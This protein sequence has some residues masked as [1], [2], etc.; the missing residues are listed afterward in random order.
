MKQ[1]LAFWNG[2]TIFF[3]IIVLLGIALR[4]SYLDSKVYWIDE[5]HTSLRASGYSRAEFV[6]LAPQ[7]EIVGIESLQKFQKLTPERN[8]LVAMK[9]ISSSEHSPFYYG[10]TRVG[11]EL[12]GSSIKV[13]RGVA[14]TLSL[15]LFPS[16]YWLTQELF[17]SR[18]ISLA[19]TALIAVSP[20]QILYAQ[21]AR[22]YSLFAVTIVLASAVFLRVIK[23]NSSIR[24][25]KQ[26]N[27]FWYSLAIAFGLYTHP[28]FVLV[29]LAH[30]FFLLITTNL[31]KSNLFKK[32]LIST[33]WGIFLFL[34]W[35]AVF[36]FNEDGVGM[37]IERDISLKFWLQRWVLNISATF[38]DFQG[39]FP[40]IL[41]DVEK[42][43]DFTFSFDNAIS[44][45]I[46]P[47][48]ALI[49]YSIYF[50]IK[51]S[52]RQ[53]SYFILLLMGV[54]ILGL[55][56]PD[57]LFGG[58]RSTIARYILAVIVSIQI[59][60]GYFFANKMNSLNA[61]QWQ[62][63]LWRGLFCLLITLSLISSWQMVQAPTWWNKYSSYYNAEVA[64]IINQ[65]ENPLIISNTERISRSTSLSYL[66]K[67]DAK[68]LL[69]DEKDTI[70]SIA[71]EYSQIFL[72]RPFDD[73]LAQ[74]QQNESYKI[75]PIF[76]QG[77]L[78]QLSIK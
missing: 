58:Q 49:F 26:F 72:F 32:Y 74:L 39:I 23:S 51:H 50:L 5:V 9:A 41:F 4:F 67:N 52:Y 16:I 48:F 29:M 7:G 17:N 19:V 34:P 43:Q 47:L 6:E 69:L 15:F 40:E 46:I 59:I 21:E 3:A 57:L 31:K 64:T 28:L 33:G 25:K 44:L 12:F 53:S 54:T 14:A 2:T 18:L 45:L 65:A 71:S 68:F 66:L 60:V 62:N 36:I 75:E 10:L 27:W 37:W 61:K 73:F 76:A 8:F 20:L 56:L 24:E 1:K 11:M 22:E 13:T 35:L 77:H 63:Q 55:G 38:F 30:G 78:Y 42:V 70:P